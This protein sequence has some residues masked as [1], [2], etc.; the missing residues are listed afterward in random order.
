[1]QLQ[2]I[3]NVHRSLTCAFQTTK[4]TTL[5]GLN[6]LVLHLPSDVE[7]LTPL[8]L[9][10]KYMFSYLQHTDTVSRG[11]NYVTYALNTSVYANVTVL[12]IFVKHK[13]LHRNSYLK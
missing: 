5:S 12:E 9:I 3:S 6:D 4:T 8:A 10:N 13:Q 11:Y 7:P 2:H 1:M